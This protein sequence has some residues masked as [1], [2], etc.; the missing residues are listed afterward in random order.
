MWPLLVGRVESSR[1]QEADELCVWPV[2]VLTRMVGAAGLTL[3][4]GAVGVK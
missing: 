1:L 3:V 2:A 4:L